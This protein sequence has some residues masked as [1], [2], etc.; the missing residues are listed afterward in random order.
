M[1]EVIGLAPSGSMGSGYNLDAFKRGVA[2]KPHFIG[3]DAGSTDMGPYYH[4]TGKTFLPLAT[5]RYDLSIMLGAA[6]ELGVPLII[7]SALT[8]GAN[9]SLEQAVELVRDVARENRQTFRMAIISSEIDKADLKRRMREAPLE[10]I[11][12]GPL[13]PELVDRCGPIV[14]QMGVEPFMRA[15]DAG[16]DVIIAGR[17]CDDVIFA[18]MPMLKGYDA[19]LALHCGKILEC[20]G[21]SAV[22]CDLA[23]PLLGRVR[24]DHFEVEPCHPDH[25]CTTVSVAGHSL[26]ERG[27]PCLQPGPGGMNDLT[28]AVFTQLDERRVKVTG[29]RF[30][31]DKTYRVKLEGAEHLGFRSVVLVGIRDPFMIRALDGL[32]EHVRERAESRFGLTAKDV[33]LNFSVYGRNAVM[34]K[35]EPAPVVDPQEVALLIDVVAPEQELATGVAMFVRGTLQHASYPGIVN[36]AGNMAY[37]FSP[38]GVPLGPA[39]R[40]AVYHLMPLADPCECFPMT[41]EEVKN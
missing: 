22:P 10:S 37:P 41:I 40:F 13:T 30:I 20:A 32:F 25:R 11:G 5:Y 3:Q 24:R 12:P 34:G 18:A 28:H 16:A 38:F 19:G 27:D 23:E 35:L 8:S 26:Y 1:E 7:G 17:A 29:S 33:Q 39:Y 21:L 2:A 4:G 31:P 6:R 14:A 15:L 9:V 36:T